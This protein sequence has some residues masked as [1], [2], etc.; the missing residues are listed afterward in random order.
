MVLSYV[1]F[2]YEEDELRDGA[3]AVSEAVGP[4]EGLYDSSRT[5]FF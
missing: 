2:K 3:S 4:R 5:N 1:P